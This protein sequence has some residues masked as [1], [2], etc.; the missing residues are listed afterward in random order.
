[1]IQ[2]II[3]TRTRC[4][5]WEVPLTRRII[6]LIDKWYKKKNQS[7]PATPNIESVKISGENM[8]FATSQFIGVDS[9]MS[10]Q[11]QIIRNSM[12]IKDSVA[13]WENI[14][15]VDQNKKPLNSNRGINLN[16]VKIPASLFHTSDTYYLKFVIVILI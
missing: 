6:Y 16:N 14:Y 9:L 4:I 15:G 7:G 12:V 13:N 1:L 11:F 2:Q 8:E 10:V 3:P 5:V